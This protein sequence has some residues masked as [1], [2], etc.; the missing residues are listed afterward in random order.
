MAICYWKLSINYMRKLLFWCL[1][2]CLQHSFVGQPGLSRS[3]AVELLDKVN[4]PENHTHYGEVDDDD[5]EVRASFIL[6]LFV[7]A[8]SLNSLLCFGMWDW[9]SDSFPHLSLPTLQPH[10]VIRHTIRST[11]RNIRAERTASEINCESLLCFPPFF[12]SV[13]PLVSPFPKNLFPFGQQTLEKQHVNL[14]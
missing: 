12:R 1:F 6:C 7:Q 2:L 9:S 10:S 13:L 5:F 3:L 11:N 4:N 8:G 14:P